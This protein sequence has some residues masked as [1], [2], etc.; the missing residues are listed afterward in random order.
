M[1]ELVTLMPKGR[2]PALMRLATEEASEYSENPV[3]DAWPS[4][5]CTS[6]PGLEIHSSSSQ[7]EMEYFASPLERAAFRSCCSL[8]ASSNLS[9]PDFSPSSD[10]VFS[11]RA[12]TG[13]VVPEVCPCS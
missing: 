10:D 4:V 11:S 8:V 5:I 13:S 3:I 6:T 9:L 1:L 7:M 2:A 12:T